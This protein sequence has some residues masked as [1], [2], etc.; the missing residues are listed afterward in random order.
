MLSPFA[1][2]QDEPVLDA[3]RSKLKS[4]AF[5]V[6][7]LAQVGGTLQFDPEQATNGFAIRVARLSFRGNLDGGFNY[8]MQTEFVSSTTLLD[9]RLGYQFNDRVGLHA[10]LFKAPFSGGFLVSA[11]RIDFVNRSL[12]TTLVPR[13]QVGVTVH[14]TNA[15]RVLAYTVGIFNGNGRTLGG[16]D[17]NS[18]MYV[19]RVVVSPPVEG[20]LDI[21]ANF[22]YSEDGAGEART[23]WR[24]VGGDLRYTRDQLLFSGE[25]VYTDNDPESAFAAGNNPFGYHVTLGY[26]IEQNVQ[27]VLL[28]FEGLQLD[29][30]GVDFRDQLVLGYNYWATRAFLLQLNY[31]LPVNNADLKNHAII[32]KFQVNI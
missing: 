8:F 1:Y 29:L 13:R 32:A 15:S 27:Q 11:A 28:R 22:S 25:V 26:M 16:N 9:A 7:V 20:R 10:G 21:G 24:R 23:T 6:G 2:A 3:L 31:L 14:G 12:L 30:P 19:G 18:M 4:D 17:N 5:S